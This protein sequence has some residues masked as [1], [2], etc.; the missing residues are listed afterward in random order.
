MSGAGE[1]NIVDGK[2]LD[3]D[4]H[5]RV[6]NETCASTE[7]GEFFNKWTKKARDARKESCS[8]FDRVRNRHRRS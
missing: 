1:S 5:L 3:T 4:P 6:S 7:A 2:P 8:I